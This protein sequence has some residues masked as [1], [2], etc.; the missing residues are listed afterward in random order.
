[1]GPAERRRRHLTTLPASTSPTAASSPRTARCRRARLGLVIGRTLGRRHARGPRHHQPRPQA[2]AVQPGDRH[3]LRLRR[4][5]RGEGR[6]ASSAAA[7]SA[8][9]WSEASTRSCARPIATRIS[10][11]PCISRTRNG[12]PRGRRT[13]MAGSASRCGSDAGQTWHCCLLYD[14]D[15]R[16]PPLPRTA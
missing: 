2:G 12:R 11:A 7:A 14:L 16:Q 5:V 1:M 3:P 8:T 9:D 15:R 13:P 10:S 6:T 4:R